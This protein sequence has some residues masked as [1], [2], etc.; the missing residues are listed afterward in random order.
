[1]RRLS[2]L[3]TLLLL[4]VGA[5][6]AYAQ[7]PTA[8]PITVEE[9]PT[10]YYFIASTNETIDN[11]ANPYI[12]ANGDYMKLVAQSAVTT[13]AGTSQVGLWYIQ[14]TGTS[15]NNKA[16]YTIR[17][18]EGSK[19]YWVADP[20][21]KLGGGTPGVYNILQ[22]SANGNEYYFSGIGGGITNPAYVNA[23]SATGNDAFGRNNS[24]ANNK[25]KLI[26][27]GVK[28]ITLNYTAGTNHFS[29]TKLAGNGKALSTSIDFYK[30]FEPSTITPNEATSDYSVTCAYNFPF[31]FGKFYKLTIRKGVNTTS[32][33]VAWNV[34]NANIDSKV[35]EANTNTMGAYWRFEIVPNT[36]N[37]VKLLTNAKGLTKAVTFGDITTDGNLATLS[38]NGTTF[39]VN[40]ISPSGHADSYT[41]A[42]RLTNPNNNGANLNDINSHL[43]VWVNNLSIT[44]EGSTFMV[45]AIDE[46]PTA[47]TSI[48][49]T[50]ENGVTGSLSVSNYYVKANDLTNL[51]MPVSFSSNITGNS[52]QGSALNVTYRNNFGFTVSSATGEKQWNFLRARRAN[53]Q[54]LKNCYLQVR[55]SDN[56]IISRGTFDPTQIIQIRNY[57]K[58]DASKWAFVKEEGTLCKFKIYNKSTGDKVLYLSSNTVNST[59]AQMVDASTVTTGFTSFFVEPNT[60]FTDYAGFTI[61]A[62]ENNYAIGD[63][64]NGVLS[65][66]ND[67]GA[68]NDHGSVFR[69]PTLIE[70]SKSAATQAVLT[71]CIGGLTSSAVTELNATN[72]DADF[73]AKFDELEA[74]NTLY[75]TPDAN[76]L[77]YIHPSRISGKSFAAFINATADAEGNILLGSGNYPDERR[78]TFTQAETP[79]VYVRFVPQNNG[80]YYLIQDVNSSFYYGYFADRTDNPS[81]NRLYL[82]QNSAHAGHYTIDNVFDGV[83]GHVGLKENI[84]TDRVKQYLWCRG[85]SGSQA[86]SYPMEFHSAY[87]YNDEDGARGKEGGCAYQVKVV[88][89]YTA[90]VSAAGFASLCLPF[91]VTL[92]ENVKAYRATAIERNN[93]NEMTLVEV[94]TT[95]PA[96]EPVILEGSEGSYTLTINADNGT[97]ATDNI[98]T[99]ATVKRTGINEEYYA[100]AKKTIDETET[101]AFFRVDTHNMPANKAYLLKKD[102]PAEA[103]NAAMFMFNFDGN[104]GEVT[105]INTATKAE[106]ES[107]VYYD[108]NG[109]RVL[110]PSHGIY[111]KGNGQKV[112]IK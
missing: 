6:S 48:S 92:P 54:S 38:D 81:E 4:I 16:S 40:T 107:N 50:D 112:F 76:K 82:V 52:V 85:E 91:S 97:K 83:L 111:V 46:Q 101:T 12:A 39:V 27:A 13:D 19:Y 63:H 11:V 100:L 79:S 64:N 47:I 49:A 8:D 17:S 65:L 14:K 88:D 106:T 15:S 86:E 3:F 72:S 33:Y 110:Y 51:E 58:N 70:D 94:G 45:E 24:G 87:A 84:A 26:P 32:S 102:I 7:T 62:E 68:I 69:V 61:R 56:K 74:A 59:D 36:R 21:C 95:I 29:V 25:W 80:A 41:N 37:Q 90:K 44:D 99:G 30:D 42:F 98:L 89:N 57:Y 67:N 5:V 73:F 109:R 108:L 71:D 20:K 105:G 10:G 9:V 28:D 18:M 1:M 31:E 23:N 2:H 55:S 66:W 34:A 77:Y 22:V 93:E 75:T 96:G 60:N 103:A 43:G 53:D 104:G 35:A 78:L